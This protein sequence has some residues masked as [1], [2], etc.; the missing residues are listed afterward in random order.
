MMA[1]KQIDMNEKK[2]TVWASLQEICDET[3]LVRDPETGRM[4]K[5]P[6]SFAS[7]KA[8][9]QGAFRFVEFFEQLHREGSVWKSDAADGF[10]FSLATGEMAYED[11]SAGPLIINEF[12]A[13]ELVEC[14]K[15]RMAVPASAE[16]ADN[17][18]ELPFTVETDRYFMAVFLF[19]YF[20]HTG[21][22]FE[23]KKMVNRCFL[24]P[25]EKELFRAEQGQFCMDIGENENTPVK[26]IQDKLIHYW[27]EYPEML[28]KMFQ[29]AFMDGGTLCELRPTEVDWKQVLV[30]LMMDC[31]VCGCGFRGFSNR[32]LP[33]EN[34]TLRCPVCGK[35]WYVL[36]DGMNRI[37][38]AEGVK[39]YACQTGRDAFD[40]DTVT[41][42]VAENRNKKGLYGIKNVSKGIWRGLFPD[43]TTREIKEGQGIPIWNGM[44]V[45]FETG[46]EWRLR[47]TPERKT[48]NIEE[49]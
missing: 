19:E 7:M 40:K 14:I 20:F 23:G 28:R 6:A 18:A 1:V 43:G 34:G 33:Q 26:G 37:L 11:S 25:L 8:L 31:Q 17:A 13:P 15:E 47:L 9:L 22:P 42:L 30:R 27:E 49:V 45:R 16:E 5:K 29:R 2:E 10:R 44:Q 3:R 35:T 41:A 36:T 24:S 48:G 21:S 4:M 38:L 39:L 46:E 32:L 12:L